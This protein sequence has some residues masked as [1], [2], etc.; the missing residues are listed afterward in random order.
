[1]KTNKEKIEKILEKL[2]ILN[3]QQHYGAGNLIDLLLALNED[4]TQ[5]DFSGLKIQQACL[6]GKGLQG[7]NLSQ[8]E[9]SRCA[10]T[11]DFNTI[12]SID[13]Y[14]NRAVAGTTSGAIN[15]WDIDEN[16][17]IES[18]T[19]HND[20][21]WAIAFSPDGELIASGS[22]D[23][24]VR[25]WN[26][27]KQKKQRHVWS[28]HTGRVRAVAF[29]PDGNFLASG[30]EDGKI[31]LYNVKSRQLISVLEK[32]GWANS[33][34][35]SPDSRLLAVG[36]QQ[37]T[38]KV[39][40]LSNLQEIKPLITFRDFERPIRSIKFSHNGQLLA[41]AGDATEIC[42]VDVNTWECVQKLTGYKKASIRAIDF[43]PDG[44]T[45]AGGGLDEQIR[46]WNIQTGE[47]IETLT[48]HKKQIRVIAFNPDPQNSTILSGAEDQTLR[49]WNIEKIEDKEEKDNYNIQGKCLKII[50]GYANPIWS[51]AFSPIK[52]FLI[53]GDEE[54]QVLRWDIFQDNLKKAVPEKLGEHSN[55]VRKLAFNKDGSFLASGS[56]DGTV[57]VW[58]INA[59]NYN[60]LKKEAA[61]GNDRVI[62][63]TFH[64][65][66][67]IIAICYYYGEKV[68]L[69]DFD[70]EEIIATLDLLNDANKRVRG[71]DVA[72][73][74]DGQILAISSEENF[75]R[76]Y[77]LENQTYLRP[78]EGHQAP[79]WSIAFREDPENNEI[80]ASCDGNGEIRLWNLE[81]YQSR[82]LEG[83]TARLRSIAFSPDGQQLVSGGDDETVKIWDVNSG[84][85][86]NTLPVPETW[87]WSVDFSFDG[88]MVAN[89][90]DNGTVQVW[91]INTEQC[92]STLRPDRP[93]EG[94]NITGIKGLEPAQ[95]E[96]L[97]QLGAIDNYETD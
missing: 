69:W 1:M 63:V 19:G 79:V 11:E 91:H 70:E 90:N 71:R 14:G 36:G 15:V 95:I 83:H 89:A 40:D 96:M 52:P 87:I 10:L 86:L 56:Y 28:D 66:K 55:L 54:H 13:F 73:S 46:I 5:Y 8:C 43:A 3:S 26:I 74:H 72:F 35:F 49:L 47:I 62:S 30:G 94:M 29:S 59:K 50:Q 18:L 23:Q 27:K 93:Y 9:I 53:S 78:L 84:E 92:I 97:K 51:I 85:C 6:Q 75:I 60:P 48:G 57:I 32:K 80:L 31:N 67:E 4:L 41:I 37:G 64:P 39:W 7:V 44:K 33:I 21:V 88:Q 77:D 45:L 17:R 34:R 12:T 82:K 61:D 42:L 16:K 76:L 58:D 65:T 68:E 20:W 2:H 22:G 24:T 38:V 25:L 81:T